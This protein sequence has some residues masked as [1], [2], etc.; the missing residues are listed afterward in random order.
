MA[1]EEQGV[2]HDVNSMFTFLKYEWLWL[3]FVL[4][5]MDL[6]PVPRGRRGRVMDSEPRTE[7]HQAFVWIKEN[8]SCFDGDTGPLHSSLNSRGVGEVLFVD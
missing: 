1:L 8:P 6:I 4:L 2:I 3:P 7:I 5:T